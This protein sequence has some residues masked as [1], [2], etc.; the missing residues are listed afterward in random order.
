MWHEIIS[1]TGGILLQQSRYSSMNLAVCLRWTAEHG[2]HIVLPGLI[3]FL[4]DGTEMQEN[5]WLS[6]QGGLNINDRPVRIKI[7]M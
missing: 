6:Y 7:F 1:L 3:M 4:F 5:F 2:L